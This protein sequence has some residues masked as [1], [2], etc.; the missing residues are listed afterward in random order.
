MLFY[1]TNIKLACSCMNWTLHWVSHFSAG[2]RGL[3]VSLIG[4]DSQWL[5]STVK[6]M[7]SHTMDLAVYANGMVQHRLTW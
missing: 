1:Y 5:K 6:G 4:F 2:Q 3:C 7:S